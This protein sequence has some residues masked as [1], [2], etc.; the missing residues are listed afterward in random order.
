[1]TTDM[2]DPRCSDGKMSPMIA[3]ARTL[4]ATVIPMKKRE[5][6][7]RPTLWLSTPMTL[8]QMKNTLATL[9]T[10]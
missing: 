10:G 3:G 1:M 4:E 5:K 8:P 7:I 9:K 2:A 6:I